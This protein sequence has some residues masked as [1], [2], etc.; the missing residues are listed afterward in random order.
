MELTKKNYQK[1]VKS[2]EPKTKIGVNCLRAFVV[3]GALCVLGQFLHNVYE[4]WGAREHVWGYV[5][6]TLVFLA[7]L[8]T[9]LGKFDNIVHFAGAGATVPITGFANAMAAPAIEH[10]KEGFIFGVTAK[11]FLIAGPVIVFGYLSSVV[12]GLIYY[13]ITRS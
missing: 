9:G 1:M 11:M 12:V 13:L 5:A 3:G 10:K 6:M 8:L 7:V 2:A 4:G